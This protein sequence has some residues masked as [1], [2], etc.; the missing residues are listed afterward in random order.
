MVLQVVAT[1]PVGGQTGEPLD[2]LAA[3]A[4]HLQHMRHG[5]GGP[6]VTGG[7]LDGASPVRLGSQIV[8][9]LLLG[10]TAAGQHGGIA[11]HGRRPMRQHALDGG[12]HVVRPAEPEIDEMA[13]PDGQHVMRVGA[14]Y[15]LP[16]RQRR[17]E[18][19]IDPGLQRGHVQLLARGGIDAQ[20]ARGG[21]G[22]AGG[23]D[24]GLLVGE[25]GHVALQ[26]M[27]Q[28]EIRGDC[29]QRGE[30]LGRI[31][32]VAEIAGYHMVER[33]GRGGGICRNRQSL[34][35]MTHVGRLSCEA[36]AAYAPAPPPGRQ[37]ADAG[38]PAI[39]AGRFRQA[40]GLAGASF[41]DASQAITRLRPFALAA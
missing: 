16:R 14:Q 9:A 19:A 12:G 41:I 7:Q 5:M 25:H 2:A 28:R 31:G 32:A 24:D 8:A 40:V 35:I 27:R 34:R 13:Q 23:G 3:A 20:P 30:A 33:R 37:R 17:V 22:L 36:G 29:Q 15:R 1:L 38:L 21:S 26:A 18:L 4:L 39:A 11:G 6:E 10:E